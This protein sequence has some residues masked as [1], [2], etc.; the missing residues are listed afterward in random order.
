[1]GTFSGEGTFYNTGLGSCGITNTDSDFICAMNYVDME[2]GA[3]PNNNPKCGR[4]VQIKGPNGS[5]TVEVTDTCPT[6][7]KGDIDLSPAA[8]AEIADFDA[9]RVD[10]TWDW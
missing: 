3:N 1:K 6:C 2:N 7:A 10:I 5:V 4:K 8:F 9:G